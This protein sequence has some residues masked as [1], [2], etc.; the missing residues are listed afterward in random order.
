[1]E[2]PRA[3]WPC[4]ECGVTEEVMERD[5]WNRMVCLPCIER[6][7]RQ[8]PWTLSADDRKLLRQLKIRVESEP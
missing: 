4:A 5:P 2:S 1:M 7:V 6:R 3:G 8:H